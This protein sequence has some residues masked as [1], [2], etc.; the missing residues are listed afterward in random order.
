MT[1][2]SPSPATTT[3]PESAS[4]SWFLSTASD[5]PVSMDSS[6]CSARPRATTASAGTWS[7]ALRIRMSSRTTSAGAISSS[8]PPRRT[9]ARG[10]FSSASRSSFA[11][12][13]NSWT[14]P[15]IAFANAARPNSASCQR[16]SS[17]RTRKQPPTIALKSVNTLALT[18]FQTLRLESAVKAFVRPAAMRSATWAGV[19][20]TAGSTCAGSASTSVTASMDHTL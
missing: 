12:A 2:A 6:I 4:S 14:H 11:L 18:M 1:C 17:R 5:S 3:E 16:P 8:S 7:P 9:R 15:M 20:P 13:R 19:S 10:A